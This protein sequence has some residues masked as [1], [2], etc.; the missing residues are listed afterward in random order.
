MQR[1]DA[2]KKIVETLKDELV[3]SNIGVPSKELHEIFDRK[4]NFYMLGSMGMATPIGFGLS[5]ALEKQKDNRKVIVID[6]DGSVLMNLGE[7]VTIYSQ[8]PSNLIIALIDNESYGSTGSQETYA[9]QVNLSNIATSIGFKEVYYYDCKKSVDNID[10]N[11]ILN[12]KGPVLL[13]IKV[14]PG[15]SK[16]PNIKLTPSEIKNRFMNEIQ[17]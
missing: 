4:E 1:Y 9:S 2:I 17:K 15:N 8:N 12:K 10:M 16:A 6:G 13:H 5:V 7:L 11:D 14:E 3:I